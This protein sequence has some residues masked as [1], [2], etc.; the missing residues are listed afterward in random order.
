MLTGLSRRDFLKTA[1]SSMSALALRPP[2]PE[3]LSQVELLARV[4][5]T[6]VG[7]Y[8]EPSFRSQRL[9]RLTRDR[10]ISILAEEL[11]DDGPSYN[12]RWMRTSDGYA[13]SGYLQLVKWDL[14]RPQ[15]R[16]PE[17]GQLFEVSV[18]Y[19]RTYREPD[20]TSTP[21]YRLY[22]QSTAW[23][24]DILNDPDGR[25]WY[26]LRDDLLNVHYFAR[27]EHLR[28][29]PFSELQ[30][31]SPDVPLHLKRI[32]VSLARQELLAFEENRLVF[33]TSVSSG[34]PDTRPRD[35]G[36]PTITPKG[37]FYVDKKMPLRH[38]GDG[39]LTADL[40][41]Y[42]LPG[43]PWVSFFTETGVAF[44]G[45]YW[46]TNFGVPMSHGCI[47]MRPE[48]AKWLY[49]WNLPPIDA[50]QMLRIGRG[51]AVVVV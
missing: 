14:Q 9:D 43:V 51:T 2:P 1:G 8:A 26:K 12:P 21:L 22:Y 50:S 29:V 33:R 20:P 42:E 5:T 28:R 27:A 47:N 46:H 39:K 10:L 49:R 32:E 24:V 13:H 7:L 17:G 15:A 44:H 45:T 19:T 31:I 35:N 37:R 40:E 25:S 11:S 36:I 41:A 6:W 48:E 34:I 18:P 38:M 16:L 30:P 4:A 3:S 23:A